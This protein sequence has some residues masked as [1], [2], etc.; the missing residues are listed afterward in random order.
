MNSTVT[1]SPQLKASWWVLHGS[2]LWWGGVGVWITLTV[3]GSNFHFEFS[4][5]L[6]QQGISNSTE[7]MMM[8]TEQLSLWVQPHHITTAGNQQQYRDSDDDDGE[9]FPLSSAMCRYSRESATIQWWRWSNF[10]F[11][12]SC[13][14]QYGDDVDNGATY[15]W[16]AYPK[17][18]GGCCKVACCGR[19]RELAT[20]QSW[21][22]SKRLMI[23]NNTKLMT[24]WKVDDQQQ[25]ST[26]NDQQNYRADDDVAT[27][28]WPARQKHTGWCCKAGCWGRETATIQSWWWS[29]TTQSWWWSATTQSWWWSATIQSW[30]WCSNLPMACLPIAHW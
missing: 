10:H 7:I 9:T 26:D 20:T 14:R 27:Y 17:H 5:I 2:W 8:M 4:H 19:D 25:H 13:Q 30:W 29:A 3:S 28:P 11:E 18:A 21:W 6:P 22:W 15:S 23:S 12:F 16:P 24:I 1:N